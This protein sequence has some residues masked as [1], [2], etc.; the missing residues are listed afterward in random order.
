MMEKEGL[1]A[2]GLSFRMNSGVYF[3]DSGRW[4]AGDSFAALGDSGVLGDSDVG[5]AAAPLERVIIGFNTM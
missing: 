3:R 2:P 1:G 5:G 4:A